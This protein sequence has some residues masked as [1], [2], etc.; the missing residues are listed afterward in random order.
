MPPRASVFMLYTLLTM[1]LD[2]AMQ[3]V[4]QEVDAELRRFFA[5]KRKEAERVHPALVELVD[6]V[7]DVTVR[8][9]KRIR[10][11]LCR[12]GYAAVTRDKGHVTGK[13]PRVL[14]SAMLGLELFQTFAI[15]HDDIMDEDKQ[16]RGGPT[17]H[18]QSGVN[19]AILSGDLALAWADEE[20]MNA[21]KVP[22]LLILY[23]K[24]KEEVMYGQTLD[25]MRSN[26]VGGIE[27]SRV[28]ELKTAYYSVVRPLQ[29]G[30][31]LAAGNDRILHVWERYGVAVGKLFQLRDDV[32]DGTV[33]EEAFARYA[34]GLEREAHEAL[35]TLAAS[36]EPKQLL[37]DFVQ[38]VQNRNS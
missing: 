31:V 24:M 6:Q 12:V 5:G 14:L 8:G 19:I 13:M 9:G 23:Q 4:K 11:F 27:K 3:T 16:R 38:F 15:I 33:A 28:D 30:S 36:D 10:P 25:V 26:G 2:N 18:E 32:L 35:E 21:A 1:K 17:I 7:A 22:T 29:I 34:R 20:M 37:I